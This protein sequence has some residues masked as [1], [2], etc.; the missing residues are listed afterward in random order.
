MDIFNRTLNQALSFLDNEYVSAGVAL[1]LVLYAG[2]AAPSL[3]EN[4]ARLFENTLFKL[5]VFFLIAYTSRR[6][7]T[8]AIIAAVGLM[9][10]LQTLNR[11]EAERKM[12][13]MIAA[14]EAEIEMQSQGIKAGGPEN[15]V[16][17]TV[18]QLE[19]PVSP[20]SLAEL[21]AEIPESEDGTEVDARD[22]FYPGYVDSG[23][24][25]LARR[26]SQQ[27]SGV[28]G[29]DDNMAPV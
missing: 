19:G 8:V 10:S 13:A 1:F 29:S 6:N 2:M 3:P 14:E 17:Q 5:L 28:E 4:I 21:Q 16:G 15:A 23:N 7:P 12:M 25:H 18:S 20:E 26:F 24:F 22:N 11:Y 9:V 27:V